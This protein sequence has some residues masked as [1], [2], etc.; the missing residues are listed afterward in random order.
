MHTLANMVFKLR[1]KRGLTQLELAELAGLS[2]STIWEIEAGRQEKPRR[3]TLQALT[4][5]LKCRRGDLL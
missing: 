3:D 4:R 2:R 5:A 1:T